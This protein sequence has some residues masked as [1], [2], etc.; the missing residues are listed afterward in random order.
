MGQLKISQSRSWA[1]AAQAE[2]A[3]GHATQWERDH[4][5]LATAE[6]A[7]ICQGRRPGRFACPLRWRPVGD[8]SGFCQGGG[9][10]CDRGLPQKNPARR[11]VSL[12]HRSLLYD[13]PD[14]ERIRKLF[15]RLPEN[16][17]T[18]CRGH[19]QEV[20]AELLM[21]CSC[22]A[23]SNRFP[24]R[25]SARL[26]LSQGQISLNDLIKLLS[27]NSADQPDAPKLHVVPEFLLHIR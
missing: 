20:V 3:R 27:G 2:A 1:T 16:I 5:Q 21:S 7:R 15:C 6:H 4:G 23:L 17:L 25:E 9:A 26:G 24:S 10:C 11:S 22:V 19:N 14:Q 13:R 8:L 12:I 18:R